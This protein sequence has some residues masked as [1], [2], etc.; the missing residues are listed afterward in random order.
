M[1]RVRLLA[2]LLAIPVLTLTSCGGEGD[3]PQAGTSKA[4]VKEAEERAQG[5]TLD[6]SGGFPSRR[7]SGRD[8]VDEP[9]WDKMRANSQILQGMSFAE[10]RRLTV[11]AWTG[12]LAGKQGM[13]E[14]DVK[15]LGWGM[16]TSH[17]ND[18]SDMVELLGYRLPSTTD[19][20]ALMAAI[21][22]EPENDGTWKTVGPGTARISGTT[23]YFV[24]RETDLMS[25]TDLQTIKKDLKALP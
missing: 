20:Q 18:A 3:S 10:T 11:D 13:A 19:M 8:K 6:M 7:F 2:A 1:V 25:P 15:L 12:T 17:P 22:F 5:S 16:Y 4:A 14:S 24:I 23:V 9:T 21:G